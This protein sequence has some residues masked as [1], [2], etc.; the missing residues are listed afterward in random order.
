MTSLIPSYADKK[1]SEVRKD[2]PELVTVEKCLANILPILRNLPKRE[3][4]QNRN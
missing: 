3:T 1:N 2:F 4:L